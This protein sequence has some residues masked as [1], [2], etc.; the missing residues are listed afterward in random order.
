MT[1][2]EEVGSDADDSA[3]NFSEEEIKQRE[4]VP[5][6]RLAWHGDEH[7]HEGIVC[8]VVALAVDYYYYYVCLI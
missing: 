1:G 8:V 7:G 6:R 3:A 4:C 5:R 2:R